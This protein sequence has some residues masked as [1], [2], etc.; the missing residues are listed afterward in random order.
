MDMGRGRVA[1]VVL[2]GGLSSRMGCDKALL[3]VYGST[4]PDLL[5]R[6]HGLLAALLPQCWVSCRLGLPRAG[7]QCLFDDK[8]DSGPIAGVL[9][10]LR[11]AQAQGFSAVLALSC[12]MPFMDAPTLRKLLAARLAAPANTLA[13]LYID[14]VSGRPEALSAV[15]ETASLPWFEDS[16]A[17]YGGRLNNVVPLER[18]CRLPYDLKESQPFFNMNRPEDLQRA[19]DILGASQ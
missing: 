18:Q 5:A 1:G 17:F 10:A 9:A 2:A 12:D 19:L 14:A 16:V 8:N 15:Y 3:R 4:S 13:T 7:Y 6:T 11:A